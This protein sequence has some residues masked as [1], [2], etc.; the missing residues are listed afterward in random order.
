MASFSISFFY[1]LFVSFCLSFS[2]S[3]KALHWFSSYLQHSVK[4]LQKNFFLKHQKRNSTGLS[5]LGPL[6]FSVFIND[7]PSICNGV[8]CQLYADNT[9]FYAPAKTQEQAADVLPACME[10]VNHW[11]FNNE[12]V[13]NLIK[14]ASMCFSIRKQEAN[15]NF[16]F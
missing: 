1:F 3:N 15:Q 13:I 6:L 5:I 8:K 10:D 11:L 16:K 9:V 7:L 12:L 14:T 2:I 4:V